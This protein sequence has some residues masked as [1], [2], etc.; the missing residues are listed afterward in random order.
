MILPAFI[1]LAGLVL[2]FCFRRARPRVKPAHAR[3]IAKADRVLTTLR[4]IVSTHSHPLPAV[5]CYLRKIDP[6]VFEE[7]TLTCLSERG[8]AVARNH[9]YSG[10]HGVD[11]RFD[12]DGRRYLAQ[13]KRYDHSINPQHIT[14]FTVAIARE[15]AAGGVFVHT[16]RTGPNSYRL[17]RDHPQVVVIS[18]KRLVSLIAQHLDLSALLAGSDRQAI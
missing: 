1:L 11:G 18:G 9:R 17:I 5:L 10:D 16:G 2:L 14:D 12:L 15:Q 8:G 3:R 4:Q 6:L 13:C 7:I